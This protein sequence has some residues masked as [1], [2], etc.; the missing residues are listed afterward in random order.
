VKLALLQ[1]S[2]S[3][4][5]VL[6]VTPTRRDGRELPTSVV[7]YDKRIEI[8]KEVSATRLHGPRWGP[9]HPRVLGVRL[10][11]K[12]AAMQLELCGGQF[13]V[14]G[15]TRAGA[16]ATFI[17]FMKAFIAGEQPTSK[18]QKVVRQAAAKLVK[19]SDAQG[20]QVNLF[21]TYKIAA[22]AELRVLGAGA[23]PAGFQRALP[24]LLDEDVV[25]LFRQFLAASRDMQC[26]TVKS[27]QGLSHSDLHGGN[28]L[29]DVMDNVW[30]IDYATTAP[31]RPGLQDFSKLL[32]STLFLDDVMPVFEEDENA[33]E[34]LC[35]RLAAVPSTSADFPLSENVLSDRMQRLETF[36]ST[37]WP[38]MCAMDPEN[39]GQPAVWGI[40]RYALRMTTYHIERGTEDPAQRRRCFYLATACAVRLHADVSERQCGWYEQASRR[41]CSRATPVSLVEDSTHVM[42]AYLGQV[43][44]VEG[45]F[46]DPVSREK[47][48]VS[49]E[50]CVQVTT[51]FLPM[52]ACPRS[53]V[54]DPARRCGS[55]GAATPSAVRATLRAKGAAKVLS[56]QLEE[57]FPQGLPERL[58]V[59]GGGGTGKTTL[60]KQLVVE[61][62][63]GAL[64]DLHDGRDNVSHF[65]PF[66]F[67]LQELAPLL[68]GFRPRVRLGRSH[69]DEDAEWRAAYLDQLSRE[70]QEVSVEEREHVRKGLAFL[71]IFENNL[72]K[73]QLSGG[74]EVAYEEGEHVLWGKSV[75][76]VH[77]PALEVLAYIWHV[78]SHDLSSHADME[79]RAIRTNTHNQVGHVV[80]RTPT[81]FAPREFVSRFVWEE[82][83]AGTYAV[84][85]LAT[86]HEEWPPNPRFVRGKVKDLYY[87]ET[88]APGLSRFTYVIHLNVGGYVP[89]VFMKTSCM[90]ALR[91]TAKI[92]TYFRYCAERRAS[93]LATQSAWDPLHSFFN[94]TFGESS[95]H[96]RALKIV[97]HKQQ[98]ALLLL[99][100]LDEAHAPK[101]SKTQFCLRNIPVNMF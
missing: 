27:T 96:A 52:R 40:L 66:R 48:C 46:V 12:M 15:Y 10:G 37:L 22:S 45:W 65:V 35:R 55:K 63:C 68:D 33:F 62:C 67:P 99:D 59:I 87:L 75:V 14:P 79:R 69:Q 50:C 95:A 19:W 23:H 9:T 101:R 36:V 17:T 6:L 76:D 8:E 93:H 1:G 98:G 43:A 7:K 32:C 38:F 70:P 56:A 83:S 5:K 82:V 60:T 81:G 71:D 16:V 57:V 20:A 88:V 41:W 4:A 28:L 2:M 73:K 18:M 29:V 44:A 58:L 30:M 91:I 3:G 80:K 54:S 11:E 53:G 74:G 42:E 89:A 84:V 25:V 78:D 94:G 86:E 24:S 21:R 100:G 92:R 85:S 49:G 64:A 13:G 90:R 72:S 34:D 26:K 51:Q 77:A 31:G 97:E 39:D 47:V 61:A